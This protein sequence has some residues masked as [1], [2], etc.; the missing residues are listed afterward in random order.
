MT[1]VL[2][3]HVLCVIQDTT[4]TVLW[5]VNHHNFT[6]TTTMLPKLLL[7]MAFDTVLD[8]WECQAHACV[9]FTIADCLAVECLGLHAYKTAMLVHAQTVQCCGFAACQDAALCMMPPPTALSSIP[10]A[11]N[12]PPPPPLPPAGSLESSKQS[13]VMT[14][15][16]T[17]TSTMPPTTTSLSLSVGALDYLL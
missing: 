1:T 7:G 14:T 15:S 2:M 11:P 8:Q 13:N 12:E 6:T 17:T 3:V 16:A 4:G 5:P 9:G 10:S